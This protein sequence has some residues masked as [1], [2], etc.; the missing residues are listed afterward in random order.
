MQITVAVFVCAMQAG[1]CRP[2][3]IRHAVLLGDAAAGS[4]VR[5]CSIT[6]ACAGGLQV[7]VPLLRHLRGPLSM[8]AAGCGMTLLCLWHSSLGSARAGAAAQMLACKL[9][10]GC[11]MIMRSLQQCS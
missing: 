11:E 4:F 7:Q 6:G 1:G 2:E 9:A 8:Q 10:T 5:S 3:P